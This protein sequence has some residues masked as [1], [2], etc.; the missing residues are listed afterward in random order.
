MFTEDLKEIPQDLMCD[1]LI[2]T[3]TNLLSSLFV[4]N[5]IVFFLETSETRQICVTSI[6]DETEGS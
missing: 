3:I 4:F 5:P 6:K 1:H 2:K